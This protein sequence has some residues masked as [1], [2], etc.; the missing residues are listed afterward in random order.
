M[1]PTRGN[2]KS[3]REPM[4]T[5]S[6]SF[7]A[8]RAFAITITAAAIAACSSINLEEMEQLNGDQART[9]LSGNTLTFRAEYGRWAEYFSEGDLSG[10]GKAW[11]DWGEEAATAQNTISDEGEV[12]SV[13]GGPH[14]WSQTRVQLLLRDVPGCGIQLR[15][16][17]RQK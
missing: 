5:R 14:E 12:C 10:A 1:K 8:A 9:T 17:N 6:R 4:T 11:G 2:L 3:A 13:Y 16:R 7:L 15:H